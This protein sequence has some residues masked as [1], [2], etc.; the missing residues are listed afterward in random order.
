MLLAGSQ[1]TAGYWRAP[2]RT[3]ERYLRLPNCRSCCGIGPAILSS[4]TRK[5]AFISSAVADNQIKL[6]GHRIE[7]QDI[8]A[9]LREATGSDLAVSVL[10]L[11]AEAGLLEIV[12]CIDAGTI[13]MMPPC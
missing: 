3:A 11:S 13:R 10:G 7:L 4:A 5:A 6:N 2:D 12:G 9:A 1:V 8:D